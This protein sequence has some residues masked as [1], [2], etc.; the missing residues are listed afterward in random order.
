[1]HN[2]KK[3]KR[4]NP[5]LP[6]SDPI[7]KF[8]YVRYVERVIYRRNSKDNTKSKYVGYSLN[9]TNI[10]VGDK[11][12]I[13]VRSKDYDPN[14]FFYDIHEVIVP[15]SESYYNSLDIITPELHF[16]RRGRKSFPVIK[17]KNSS[18]K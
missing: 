14:F 8:K 6:K 1:M 2:P 3:A 18:K 15:I 5:I 12:F 13:C 4:K 16:H 7:F 9:E 17:R 10:K 11:I